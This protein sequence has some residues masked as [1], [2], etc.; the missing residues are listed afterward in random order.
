MS[1]YYGGVTAPKGCYF[2]LSSWEIAYVTEIQGVLPGDRQARYI[3]VPEIAIIIL[4]PFLG[5]IYILLLP[6]V[7]IVAG[8]IL[9]G[10]RLK[11]LIFRGVK[12][13]EAVARPKDSLR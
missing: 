11:N 8:I 4:S 9:L 2:H 3:K 1:R 10:L 13:P 5:L 7:T 12:D 6:V